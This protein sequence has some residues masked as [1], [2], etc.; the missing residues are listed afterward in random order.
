MANPQSK[1]QQ[2]RQ[3]PNC[4]YEGY[5]E[6]SSAKEKVSQRLWASLCGN[7]LFFYNTIKDVEYVDRIDLD[8]FISL[9]DDNSRDRNLGAARFQLRTKEGEFKITVPTLENRELWKGFIHAVAEHSVPSTLNLLPGQ[10]HM[11]Q[12]VVEKEQERQNTAAVQDNLYLSLVADMPPCFHEVSRKE[13]MGLLEKY[14]DCGNML[15]RPSKDGFMAVTTRQ[16]L[17]GSVFHHYRVIRRPEGGFL[18]NLETPIPC[19]NL[20]E[21]IKCLEEKTSG[22][23][24]P[25]ILNNIY[26]DNITLVQQNE[27]NGEKNLKFITGSPSLKAPPP[28]S[29]TMQ[30]SLHPA[31]VP[32]GPSKTA[33]S[34]KKK[35]NH[36]GSGTRAP[37]L[38]PKF[39]KK[40][41]SS[42]QDSLPSNSS[43]EE[44]SSG[45]DQLLVTVPSVSAKTGLQNKQ[46]ISKPPFAMGSSIG[47]LPLAFSEELK[48]KVEERQENKK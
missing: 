20:Y 18:I 26:N 21:V 3:I 36:T 1:L 46:A 11:L 47:D 40:F 24:Q 2:R 42:V 43:S 5:L 25:F 39:V 28:G 12:E 6:K 9:L 4:Y 41:V 31:C 37:M 22:I 10:V 16:D 14:A 19:D 29:N 45:T 15:L 32:A 17:N 48:K 33:N 30:E 13:A 23:L 44:Q 35:P 8:G 38:L 27:E 7:T 34:K